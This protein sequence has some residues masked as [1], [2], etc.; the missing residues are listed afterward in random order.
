VIAKEIA[1][2]RMLERGLICIKWQTQNDLTKPNL[3]NLIEETAKLSHRHVFH[4]RLK[5]P[6]LSDSSGIL[7]G[8]WIK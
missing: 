4:G 6:H 7:G 8:V 1:N 5:Q 3:I 2:F